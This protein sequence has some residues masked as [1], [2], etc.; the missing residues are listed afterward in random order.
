MNSRKINAAIAEL[1]GWTEIDKLTNRGKP[2]G[3]LVQNIPFYC[4]DLNAM[5]EAEK[6]ILDMN[7][8]YGW[9]LSR[10]DC[11][12]IW[13]ATA[14]ERAEAFLRLFDKWEVSK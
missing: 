1:C 6:I 13:H 2:P 14:R 7:D 4:Q 12:T 8:G 10:T 11:F 5:H 9:E 3:R